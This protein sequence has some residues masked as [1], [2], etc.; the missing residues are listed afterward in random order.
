[1][2]RAACLCLLLL[3]GPGAAQCRQALA[4]G[5]DVSGSVD[6]AEYTL[7]RRGLAN[8]LRHPEVARALLAMPSAPVRL[9]VYEWSDAGAQRVI[10]PWTAITDAAA[11]QQAAARLESLPRAALPP[12]TALGQAMRHGIAQLATQRDCWARTLD[13][14]GDGKSNSGPRPGPIRA[15][16]RAAGVTINALVIGA[17]ARAST[18][19]RY[20][21]IGELVS[22]FH[23]YV[24][25]GPDA[26]VET[27][28][29]FQDYEA[30][31]VRKLK[32][33]LRG[34]VLSRTHP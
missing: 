18:D 8:A 32:R 21:E 7:Q 3:A 20:V 26:F 30:A 2:I 9:M 29:G 28:L 31:M 33:E 25:T 23:A 4:L 1:M 13:I 34:L 22:Y 17:D 15:E 6:S 11:L 16:A 10:L 19:T 14:S 12:S 5:L 27:A 24:I